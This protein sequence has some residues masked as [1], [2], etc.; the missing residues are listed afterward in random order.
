MK[1]K[2]YAL[3]L[4]T[5]KNII[6]ILTVLL[7]T[8]SLFIFNIIHKIPLATAIEGPK[9]SKLLFSF[10]D[11][12]NDDYGPGSY[13]YPLS[14]VYKANPYMFDIIKVRIYEIGNFY[15]FDVEF[16]GKIVR[17][18]PG[19]TGH[20]N[21][22]LFN[23]AEIYID[24]DNKWGSGH[25]NAALGRNISF[26]PE[27][28]W[29][30]M[31]FINP[32][33]NDIMINEI[34]NKTDDLE[35]AESLN[36]IIF[37]ANTDIYGYTLSATIN[38]SEIGEYNDKW[39]IQVL[40]TVF[41]GSSSSNTFYNKRIYKSSSD[42]NF[43]GA[44]DIFGAPNVLDIIVPP[45][46]SQKEILSKYRVHPNYS[47]AKFAVVPMVYNKGTAD[48]I[49]IGTLAGVSKNE[50]SQN[51]LNSNI[52]D[53]KKL[54][55]KIDNIKE[56]EYNVKEM[57]FEEFSK[58]MINDNT[59]INKNNEINDNN[60]YKINKNKSDTKLAVIKNESI[61]KNNIKE[62]LDTIDETEIE[63][64]NTDE[65]NNLIKNK[66]YTANEKDNLIDG[67]GPLKKA[68]KSEKENKLSAVKKDNKTKNIDK[69]DGFLA[70]LDAH[71]LKF[72]NDDDEEALKDIEKFL[73]GKKETINKKKTSSKKEEKEEIKNE[74]SK[75]KE[76]KNE[77]EQ[78]QEQEDK[79]ILGR[80]FGQSKKRKQKNASINK[81]ISE[82]EMIEI[83]KNDLPDNSIKKRDIRNES[84][85]GN[86]KK[87]DKAVTDEEL[88]CRANMKKLYDISL[89]YI[90]QNPEARKISINMLISSGLLDRPLK[91]ENGGRYLI[92]VKNSKPEI[93]C[94]NVNNTGHGCYPE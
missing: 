45:G 73:T 84:N 83:I 18:W 22:W 41:D 59:A 46:A 31:V 12:K 78:E 66:S 80:L 36:D 64:I 5:N 81:S 67:I 93:S 6:K 55:L 85:A 92:E 40:S 28:Y 87:S 20:R 35:F 19:Y 76:I 89:K 77:R 38:K 30:K 70:K 9:N 86:I 49:N 16:K 48:S 47:Y 1:L 37:P 25:K 72:Q 82:N 63:N 29:E 8:G 10:N 43:G 3:K 24:T 75:N 69:Y 57:E 94:I 61:N 26:T 74:S 33:A 21:G 65:K 71:K 17:S 60:I 58:A 79:S 23:V 4:N 32:V 42:S 13:T 34:R 11:P 15:R 14:A 62:N 39:G 52:N 54:K 51:I 50:S 90:E 68:E 2:K 7:L 56:N 88:K 44:S 53:N 91:C 27:S